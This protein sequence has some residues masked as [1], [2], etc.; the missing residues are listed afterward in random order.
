MG[1]LSKHVNK[2]PAFQ[3]F[4]PHEI[5]EWLIFAYKVIAMAL[6]DG[7][8]QIEVA[9]DDVSWR[10]RSGSRALELGFDMRPFVK[11]VLARDPVIRARIKRVEGDADI[12]SYQL[13]DAP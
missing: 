3:L 2:P 4:G 13:D 8:E 7:A 10:G 12:D 5:S 6:A 1:A 9:P 11:Q